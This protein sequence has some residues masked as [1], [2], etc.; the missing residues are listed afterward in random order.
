MP[1][2]F[3]QKPKNKTNRKTPTSKLKSHHSNGILISR[4]AIIGAICALIIIALG[5]A[6]PHAGSGKN[7]AYASSVAGLG[8]GIY[9]DQACTN[10]TLSF[11]WGSIE[12]GSNSTLTVYIRN[13]GASAVLLQLRTSNWTPIISQNYMTLNWNYS[14][15]ALSI[16]EEIPL[17]L[18][19]TVNQTISGITTFSFDTII[20]NSEG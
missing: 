7:V 14:G 6:S 4:K 1:W 13:E 15:Q 3:L 11:Q 16:G 12:A 17:Q 19:L 20:T 8:V 18:T 2:N 10:R 9:Q 5:V